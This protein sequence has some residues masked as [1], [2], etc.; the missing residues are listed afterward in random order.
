MHPGLVDRPAGGARRPQHGALAAAAERRGAPFGSWLAVYLDRVQQTMSRGRRS[1]LD[2]IGRTYRYGHAKRD[3]KPVAKELDRRRVRPL[4]ADVPASRERGTGER[5]AVRS[6]GHVRGPARVP[7]R[8]NLGM[9]IHA[10]HPRCVPGVRHRLDAKGRPEATRAS[11]VQGLDEARASRP[12]ACREAASGTTVVIA[13][14]S[15]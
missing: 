5:F 9:H 13:E 6:V 8:A 10:A 2:G 14:S 4:T 12:R 7:S 1:P 15:Y 3:P 11:G